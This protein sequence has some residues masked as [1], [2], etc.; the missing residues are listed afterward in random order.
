MKPDQS[1][2]PLEANVANVLV[3]YLEGVP[4]E[5]WAL[6]G[7]DAMFDQK[8]GLWLTDA[9]W[10][11]LG[12]ILE[13][14]NSKL[15]LAGFP[16]DQVV[17]FRASYHAFEAAERAS[18]GNVPEAVATALVAATRALGTSFAKYPDSGA[19]ARE[20]HFNRF[21]PFFKA[22]IANGVA[23]VLLLS[24]LGITAS[25]RTTGGKL[26]A[27]LYCLGM[28][29]PTAGTALELYGFALRLRI[30]GR[31]PVANLYETVVWVALATS[32]LGLA[33]EL[34]WRKKY[35]ALA[36]SAIAFLATSLAD[37]VPLL[38]PYNFVVL[39]PARINRWLT[40][41]V[42]TIVSS[43][44]AFALAWGLGL[45]AVGH[46]LTAT[47]RR[48]RSYRDLAW[49]LLP[50]IPLYLLG[51]LGLEPSSRLLPPEYLGSRSLSD[52][53]SW[54][55]AFG[56]V[57]S[58]V[59]GLGMLGELAN[60]S[61]RRALALGVGLAAAAS[62]G[63]L[64]GVM[65]AVQGPLAIALTSYETCLV[66][67][68]GA[69]LTVMGVLGARAP[70]A[71]TRIES[72]A[73]ISQHSLRFGVLLFVAGAFA[74]G[75]WARDNWSGPWCYDP[76][77]VWALVT[78]AVYL[79]PVL[80]QFTGWISTFGLVAASVVCFTAVVASWYGLNAVLRGGQHS[81]GFTD[82]HGPPIVMASTL[83][84]LAFVGAAA[85]RRSRSQ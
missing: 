51:R 35:A 70:E 19:M 10:M 79:V 60:R 49:P 41:H 39:P 20:S 5:Q 71:F 64:V 17:A 13:S 44:A 62:T 66:A 18:P 75:A 76:R 54:L 7:E 81:Y 84:L 83:A 27:A 73:K 67:V 53:S 74:G 57:L 52:V 78:F 33:V 58:I 40:A 6:P 8:F 14:D 47:Y 43:Y 63:L 11:P 36:A 50:G 32:V 45:L 72:L 25:L 69:S 24:S 37:V 12:V 82:G 61:P 21:A 59:G 56:G 4:S 38:G 26:G 29:G 77:V 85:W 2:S 34:L 3:D 23:F 15:A 42:L 30:F 9:P 65:K 80:G 31:V 48:S 16:R 1:L 68:V 46:Y 22:T 55:A 28:I